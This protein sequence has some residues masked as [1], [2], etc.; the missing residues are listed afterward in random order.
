MNSI[1]ELYEELEPGMIIQIDPAYAFDKFGGCL[2]A[3]QEVKSWGVLAYL[4]DW[5]ANVSGPIFVR[6]PFGKFERTGG[7]V[8]WQQSEDDHAHW[9]LSTEEE[10]RPETPP[11]GEDE[12]E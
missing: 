7:K 6:V 10:A 8:H 5:G 4:I 11:E 3:I 12:T 9:R 2:M 1:A